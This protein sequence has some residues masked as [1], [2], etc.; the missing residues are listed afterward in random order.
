[1]SSVVRASCPVCKAESVIT[2]SEVKLVA[3]AHSTRYCWF[4][5]V[6]GEYVSKKAEPHLVGILITAGVKQIRAE[7]EVGEGPPITEDDLIEFGRQ[8]E[9][10]P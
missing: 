7:P 3:C 9:A 5:G 6:C 1:M 2:P 4:C 8:M 10:T